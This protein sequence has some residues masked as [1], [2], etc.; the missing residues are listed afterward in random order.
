M[1]IA[2]FIKQDL[3]KFPAVQLD[4]DARN[5]ILRHDRVRHCGTRFPL[6][7]W[8]DQRSLSNRDSVGSSRQIKSANIA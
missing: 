6:P 5:L 2:N 3:V 7:P 1:G 8:D 4:S